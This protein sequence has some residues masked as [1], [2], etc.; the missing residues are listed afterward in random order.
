MCY[1]DKTLTIFEVLFYRLQ[2]KRNEYFEPF[3]KVNKF[4]AAMQLQQMT[5][6]LV[7]LNS[8]KLTVCAL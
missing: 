3:S 6:H 5:A 2:G 7:P 8:N 4:H 1:L